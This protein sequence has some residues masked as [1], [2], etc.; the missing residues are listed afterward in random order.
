MARVITAKVRC[1]GK[2]VSGTG[3]ALSFYADYA[4]GKNEAWKLATP[5]LN[6]SMTVNAEA[7]ALF[8]EGAAYT[9]QFVAE[10][11]SATADE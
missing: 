2:S 9:L 3:F 5:T 10:P 1:S 8:D 7:G 4:D 11:A 6:L